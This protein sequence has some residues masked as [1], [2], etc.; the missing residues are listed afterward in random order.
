MCVCACMSVADCHY[1]MG[2]VLVPGV[3]RGY[4]VVLLTDDRNLR[5]KAHASDQPVRDIPS[6]MKLLT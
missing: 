3:G 1:C 6:F 4:K 5:V 2:L